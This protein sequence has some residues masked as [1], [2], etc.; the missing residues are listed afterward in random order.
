LS[1]EADEDAGKKADAS[2]VAA[3]AVPLPPVASVR[4]A[5]DTTGEPPPPSSPHVAGAG[6]DDAG[7]TL[8]ATV[9]RATKPQLPTAVIRAKDVADAAA[10]AA[11]GV[12]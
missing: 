10:A 12:P 4:V 3:R 7:T 5:A 8:T 2:I 11:G 9:R 6:G 1:G